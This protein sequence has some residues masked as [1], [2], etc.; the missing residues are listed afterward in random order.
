MANN[1]LEIRFTDDSYATRPEVARAL[2]TNLIDSIW[3][4][5]LDYR[6]G[7]AS[8]SG[9]YDV[10]KE[11]LSIVLCTNVVKK[12]NAL[13]ERFSRALEN[14]SAMR[15]NSIERNTLRVDMFKFALRSVAKVKGI[16]INDIALENIVSGRN[17]NLLYEP[18]VNY[19]N[20]LMRFEENPSSPID[21]S[22]LANYLEILSGGELI[23]FYRT[24][25]IAVPSQKVLI[26]REYNGAPV[27]QIEPMMSNLIDFINRPNFE[28]SI[29]AAIVAYMMNYI[30]PFESFN[31]EITALLIKCVLAKAGLKD[32]ASVIPL[33]I[34][35]SNDKDGLANASRESQKSKDL[36]YY[37]LEVSR[38]FDEALSSLLDRIVQVTRDEVE[39][40]MFKEPDE[41]EEPAHSAAEPT[42]V[43]EQSFASSYVVK[44]EPAPAPTYVK[45]RPK[46]EPV[47]NEP[48][49]NVQAYQQLDEKALRAAAEELLESDPHLR[50]AQAHFYVRHCSVGKYYTIQQF[51]KAEGVVYETARTSMDNLA[52]RGYYRR[53]Q[54]KNKFVYTP[55]SKE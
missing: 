33:E 27:N 39:K 8:E 30:K 34:I 24:S 26:N 38:L 51:K 29:K 22:L 43:Y 42:P 11:P 16:I 10:Y 4:Q 9:L 41:P 3:K 5:I 45:P 32:A 36:T 28:I 20:A 46:V 31:E 40:E 25:E 35:L 47:S 1:S 37:A 55:I 6:H 14:Y 53:E 12:M 49:V 17:T 21:E 50:P 19:F 44:P 48:K 2:G 52:K 7:F 54:V 13:S 15:V 23:S 18:L